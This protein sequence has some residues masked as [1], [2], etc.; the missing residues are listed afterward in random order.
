MSLTDNQGGDLQFRKMGACKGHQASRE[1]VSQFRKCQE[2]FD[3]DLVTDIHGHMAKKKNDHV[4]PI[5]MAFQILPQKV[6]S[7]KLVSLL[8][9]ASYYYYI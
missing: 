2:L 1:I 3:P 5:E 7:W 6:L 9:I 4:A 8:K